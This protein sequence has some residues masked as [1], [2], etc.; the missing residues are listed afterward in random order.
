MDGTIPRRDLELGELAAAVSGAALLA[1]SWVTVAT[2]DDVPAAEARAFV[3]ANRLPDALWPVVWAPVQVGSLVGSLVAVAATAVVTRRK[4]LAGAALL[5]SQGAYWGAKAVKHLVARAR[6]RQ[7]LPVVRVR[8]R[9][10]GL[11]YVSGHS[12]VAFALAIVVAPEIPRAW[13]VVPFAVA[14][15]VGFGR[16]Y[17]GV[18]LPLDVVGGVG[19]GILT[20]I[21]GRWVL[22]RG[23]AGVPA[24]RVDAPMAR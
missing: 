18:H 15:G 5:A 24:Q 7:L 8:E 19:L 14:T 1:A 2:R 3:T 21:A 23:G 12:A 17:A 4:R 20:G 10:T 6:P 9:A 16:V 13:R 22:G 11:G